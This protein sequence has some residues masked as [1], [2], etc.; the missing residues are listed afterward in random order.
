MG[1]S[2]LDIE[3]EWWYHETTKTVYFTPPDGNTPE[4]RM[5]RGKRRDLPQPEISI[6][7][8]RPPREVSIMDF[9]KQSERGNFTL[10]DLKAAPSE[11]T[12]LSQ[13]HPKKFNEMRRLMIQL[14]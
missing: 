7:D 13:T 3:Q 8:A 14:H 5:A 11:T 6:S 1:L 12:D 4:L 10:Y 9:I 2:A